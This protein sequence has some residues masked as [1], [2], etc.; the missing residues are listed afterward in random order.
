MSTRTT[1]TLEDDV[2]AEVQR[3]VHRTGRSF[4]TVVNEALRAGLRSQA[5]RPRKPFRIKP[6][7]MGL[8]PG[9]D[10]DDVESLLDLI[11]GP[12]RR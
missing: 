8:R 6:N 11:E 5:R 10:L 2:A 9:V 3:E 4:K 1:L 7:D 12:D